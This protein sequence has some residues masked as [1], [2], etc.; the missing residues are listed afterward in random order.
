MMNKLKGFSLIELMIVVAILGIL[1]SIAYPSY[2][3]YVTR[4][5]RAD[6]V[7]GLVHVAN[8]QEQY[9][10]DHRRYA[11]DM[12]D[13]GL[14]A[15]PWVVENELYQIGAVLGNNNRSFVLTATAIGAQATR[16]ND[17]NAITLNEVN[18]KGPDICWE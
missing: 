3:D 16:D 18:A 13:L 1:A 2:V 10:L 7:A 15:N 6:A 8:L 5:A 17:C 12:T 11:A 14:N 9:Y 4:S